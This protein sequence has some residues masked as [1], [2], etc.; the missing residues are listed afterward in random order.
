MNRKISLV[1]II[2]IINMLFFSG[3]TQENNKHTEKTQYDKQLF[4]GTWKHNLVTGP[5]DLPAATVE[6]MILYSNGT[7]YYQKSITWKLTD[8]TFIIQRGENKTS[9]EYEFSNSNTKLELTYNN[10]T[11]IWTKK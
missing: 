11:K 4:V 3:C 8:N 6:Q 7:G 2:L 9:Y 10:K 1:L 5:P